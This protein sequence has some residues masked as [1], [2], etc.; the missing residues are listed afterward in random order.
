[1]PL[2]GHLC[3][4]NWKKLEIPD[5]GISSGASFG[6]G[7]GLKLGNEWSTFEGIFSLGT[8]GEQIFLFCYTGGGTVHP[9]A[10]LSY[11][12]PFS[13]PGLPSYMFNESAVPDGLENAT[14]VLPRKKNWAFNSPTTGTRE[15]VRPLFLDPG[16]W[17]GS[18]DFPYKV[19]RTSASARNRPGFVA[20][21]TA[22]IA[23]VALFATF[24][25]EGQL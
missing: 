8:E 18:D 5:G 15:Q 13:T 19:S 24:L 4:Q 6:Y 2:Y 9:L 12:G 25:L 17:Q 21:S 10:A 7:D 16:K 20:A 22:M 11:N 14:I 23:G 1:M 3:N